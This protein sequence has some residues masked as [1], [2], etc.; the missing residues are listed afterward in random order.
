MHNKNGPDK[1]FCFKRFQ[2]QHDRS[3]MKVGTDG[4]LLGSWCN[5]QGVNHVLDIG[6]GSGLIALIVAQRTYQEVT[7]DAVESDQASAEQALENFKNSPWNIRL[8][9]YHTLI[10]NWQPD[11]LYDA[12]VCNPPFF[13]NGLASP[14]SRRS[15]SRHTVQLTHEDLL[16]AAK[17]LLAPLGRF[18]MILPYKEGKNFLILA[19]KHGLFCSRI[20][21]VKSK[22]HNPV[23][24]LLLEFTFESK[25]R[26]VKAL[27]LNTDDGGRSRDYQQLVE[28]FY[29]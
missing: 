3:S 22:K 19:S 24:R 5:V 14:N 26:E 29:L 2:I 4:V 11:T 9:I 23:E 13:I 18:S 10:Q 25:V 12:I 28:D 21:E 8:K 7:I 27:T 15:S 17:R 1:V 20:T 6:T 16:K